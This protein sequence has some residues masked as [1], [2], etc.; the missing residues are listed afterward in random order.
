[1]TLPISPE[2][3]NQM[4]Q[5]NVL[6]LFPHLTKSIPMDVCLPPFPNVFTEIMITQE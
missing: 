3:D 2:F 1:M 4:M 5:S 6:S